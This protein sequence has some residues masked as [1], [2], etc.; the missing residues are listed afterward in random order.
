MPAV[1]MALGS[2]LFTVDTAAFQ[3]LERTSE[4]RWPLQERILH[5]PTAQWV[6]IGKDQI[7][8]DGVIYGAF[9]RGGVKAGTYQIQKMR[10]LAE[11]G[12]EQRLVDGR[13]NDYGE[14]CILTI[15]ERATDFA[16]HGGPRKQKFTITITR[17][18]ESTFAP[19]GQ[20]GQGQGV[21]GGGGLQP[22]VQGA[23]Q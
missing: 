23:G 2:Y 17:Q 10:E 16:D 4:Y 20:G 11:T 21:Q 15:V 6:G 13:G 19:E 9:D 22:G 5:R 12:V 3:E 1:M 14:W 7:T 18:G 8:F